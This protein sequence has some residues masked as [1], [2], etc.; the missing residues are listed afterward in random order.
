MS[1]RTECIVLTDEGLLPKDDNSCFYGFLH[2]LMQ[3]LAANNDELAKP[4]FMTADQL[5]S[6]ADRRHR[7]TL[8][9]RTLLYSPVVKELHEVLHAAGCQY[10]T[11]PKI[12][13]L[14]A[15]KLETYSLLKA[16]DVMQPN[17]SSLIDLAT[18]QHFI[19]QYKD[20][21]VKPEW[22]GMGD[23]VF[24]IFSADDG[25]L[26][27]VWIEKHSGIC[28]EK[29]FIGHVVDVY[30]KI[31]DI[32][33]QPSPS[34]S[35][36][37]LG[38]VRLIVQEY[39]D[40]SSGRESAMDIRIIEQRGSDGILRPVLAHGRHTVPITNISKNGVLAEL[41]AV[42]RG[43]GV[44]PQDLFSFCAG[45][46]DVVQSETKLPIGEVGHD[47]AVVLRNGVW[48]IVYLEG[49]TMPGYVFESW[50]QLCR[51]DAQDYVVRLST[52]DKA[53]LGNPLAYA[54]FLQD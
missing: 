25:L 51:A 34:G 12:M 33:N 42:L 53:L 28:E 38:S 52:V 23:K 17:T 7:L 18:L 8:L 13:A 40:L 5:L 27:M 20:V 1:S 29:T 2:L 54:K 49:N 16:H 31:L 19:S 9:D 44:T 48:Q 50:N 11:H 32:S 35:R 6:V 43:T 10:I 4:V 30:D 15:S 41:S 21:V 39:L 14:F 45:I 3:M 47:V 22:G 24:F 26:R 36:A 46:D 37:S